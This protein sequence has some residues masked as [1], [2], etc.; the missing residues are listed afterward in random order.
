MTTEVLQDAIRAAFS[1]GYKQA[2]SGDDRLSDVDRQDHRDKSNDFLECA[3]VR[4]ATL[5]GDVGECARAELA[6]MKG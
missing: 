4:L 1:A 3:W 6:R 5:P 2:L